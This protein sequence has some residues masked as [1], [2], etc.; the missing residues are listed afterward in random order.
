VHG[1]IAEPGI[2]ANCL[3]VGTVNTLMVRKLGADALE[4]RR[5][6]VPLRTEGTGWDVG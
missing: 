3:I 2:R 5:K 6:A 4:R 1:R